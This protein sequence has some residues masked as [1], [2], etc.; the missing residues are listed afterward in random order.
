MAGVIRMQ[1]RRW[2]ISSDDFREVLPANPKR[3]FLEISISTN[4]GLMPTNPGVVHMA[5]DGD[6]VHYKVIW[7][8]SPFAPHIAP[9]NAIRLKAVKEDPGG[10][11]VVVTVEVTEGIE[12]GA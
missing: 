9:S 10:V 12:E 2:E 8:L 7:V 6:S 11:D 1:T 4:T 3:K 5:F